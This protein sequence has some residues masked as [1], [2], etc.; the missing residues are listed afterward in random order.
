MRVNVYI[1]VAEAMNLIAFSK[2]L[3]AHLYHVFLYYF[4]F[5]QLERT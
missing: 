5:G 2:K 4:S 1:W 3:N